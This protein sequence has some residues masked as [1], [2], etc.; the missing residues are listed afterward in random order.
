MAT[1]STPTILDQTT[2]RT[3]GES[4]TIDAGGSL[5]IATDTRWHSRAPASM[6]G[7]LSN[8]TCTD[9]ECIIDAT[10]VRWM[11]ITG[12]SGTLASGAIIT[13]G[14]VSGH[15]LG[16]WSS[17]TAVPSLTIGASGYIKFRQVTG[18]SFTAGPLTG[19]QATAAGPDVPGWIEVVLDQSATISVPRLGKWTTRGGWFD[20]DQTT[21]IAGQFIQIPTNGGGVGTHVPAVWIETSPSSGVFEVYPALNTWANGWSFKDMSQPAAEQDSRQKFVSTAG[22]GQ[23]QVGSLGTQTGTYA[24]I[25]NQVS[26]YATVGHSGTYTWSGNTVTVFCSG[27]HFLKTG[28]STGLDFTTG[29]ATDGI[30]T[31]TVLDAYNFTVVLAGSGTGGNVTSKPYIAITFTNHGNNIGFKLLCDFTTGTGVDGTY[32]VEVVQSANVVWVTHPHVVSLTSGAVT[33]YRGAT[34]TFSTAHGMSIGQRADIVF[35]TGTGANGIYTFETIPTTTTAFVNIPLNMTGGNFTVNW[36]TGYVPPAGCRVRIPNILGRQCATGTRSQNAVPNLTIGNRPEFSTTSAGYIDV[37]NMLDDWYYNLS[38]PY[39]VKYKNSATFDTMNLTECATA[40]ELD[41]FTF[42]MYAALALQVLTLT[43]NFAG[44]YIGYGKAMRGNVPAANAHAVNITYCNDLI[45]NNFECGIVQ[46]PRSSGNP[47]ILSTCNNVLIQNI[48]ILN[49]GLFATYCNNLNIQS[50]DFCDRFVGY[51]NNNALYTVTL[52]AS[53]DVTIAN[54]TFG[55]S[56]T[57]PNCHPFGGILNTSGSNRVKLRLIGT[58]SSPIPVGNWGPNSY[59]FPRFYNTGGNNN[60]VKLQEL[61]AE[62]GVATWGTTINS[63][64]NVLIENVHYKQPWLIGARNVNNS[65]IAN[66]NCTVKNL[67][68]VQSLVGQ[69]SVYGTHWCN[70]FGQ[71]GYGE[72]I[73]IMNEP[74]AESSTQ[75][76]VVSGPAKFNSAG[77]LILPT[78][79]NEVIWETPGWIRGTSFRNTAPLMSPSAF[80]NYTVT[81][82]IDTGTGYGVFKT[83]NAANLSAE[84]IPPGGFKLKISI[85]TV[86]VNTTVIV[87]LTLP[88]LTDPISAAANPYPLDTTTVTFTGLPLGCDVVVLTAGST[89]ILENKDSLPST[90]Y[91]FTYSGAQTVDVGFI[92]PG[93]VPYYIRGLQLATINSTIPISLTADR[94]YI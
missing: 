47:I 87:Y 61:Y 91:G 48:K 41:N 79:G 92:K 72:L 46:Y 90:S 45:I 37:E 33:V 27:G 67:C 5:T 31:V 75:V 49:Q 26:T 65:A 54:V 70:F 50:L 2:N 89:T 14:A 64:K 57:V 8:I 80:G 81:Y 17:L 53:N 71:G 44:G 9:G 52:L 94:N 62:S 82:S 15:F 34:L 51:T 59:G 25:A 11:P 38:Q 76:S 74:T 21:G 83:L 10:R 6:T 4:W 3:A 18:G 22:S 16:F 88:T 42:G 85:R 56:F 55:R 60:T 24:N 40:F 43:S 39:Y 28:Q 30:Y 35:N 93:Y 36:Q 7:S 68:G 69:A 13:Q 73:L 12:G 1:I 78:I 20:L 32:T 77:G 66:L 19:I 23:I 84:V 86:V 29:A 63:D 58:Q